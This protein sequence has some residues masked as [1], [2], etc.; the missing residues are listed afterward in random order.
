V[1]PGG[2][3][4]QLAVAYVGR[5]YFF[6]VTGRI[7]PAK[8]PE[9]VD[10]KLID[11]Y[12]IDVSKWVRARRKRAGTASIQYLRLERDFVLL[13]THGVH[14][15]FEREAGRIRDVRREPIKV[16]CYS[17]GY[18]GSAVRVHIERG[19]YLSLR[20]YFSEVST[21][22]TKEILERELYELPW[23]P[24]A[25]VMGQYLSLYR[26]INE[27]RGAANLSPLSPLCVPLRRRIYRPFDQDVCC[28]DTGLARRTKL[29]ASP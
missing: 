13:A 23:E 12:G 5:G 24:Y 22:R 17:I 4:Q 6:Y 9:C 25:P 28:A 2:F 15:F 26:L 3:V 29:K 18:R 10:V 1:L 14:H 11:L 27:R 8:D 20:A 16:A 19:I 7:P 21:R